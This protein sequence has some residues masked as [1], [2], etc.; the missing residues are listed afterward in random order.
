MAAVALLAGAYWLARPGYAAAAFL[1]IPA[2]LLAWRSA[3]RQASRLL[4]GLV[5]ILA[6]IALVG[7]FRLS[8][9]QTTWPG[10]QH[11][12]TERAFERLAEALHGLLSATE[13]LAEEA[14]R[15]GDLPCNRLFQ[16]LAGLLPSGTAE[17]AVVV[18]TNRV[19][20]LVGRSD[21]GGSVS[22]G[23]DLTVQFERYHAAFEVRRELASGRVVLATG[24]LWVD[25]AVPR[26]HRSLLARLGAET[27]VELRIHPPGD[28]TVTTEMF[29]YVL[30]AAGGDRL[31]FSVEPVPPDSSQCL[32]QAERMFQRASL[33]PAAHHGGRIRER[34][35]RAGSC[36]WRRGGRLALVA[37]WRLVVSDRLSL[38]HFVLP[39]SAVSGLGGTPH[40]NRIR[41]LLGAGWLVHGPVGS[42]C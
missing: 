10:E 32:R 3:G 20:R 33:D 26:P 4:V 22:D 23:D 37:A 38:S 31:L 1:L 36:C 30:P 40:R 13:H 11:R 5:V 25:P 8:S 17:M 7:S 34:D 15:V 41:L 12:R 39:A 27:G 35:Q 28:A 14:E 2:L 16:K 42:H 18:L 9:L 6:G 19:P 24:L 29:D 21:T